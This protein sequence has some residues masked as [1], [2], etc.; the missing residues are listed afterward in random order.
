MQCRKPKPH[1]KAAR[2]QTDDSIID[3]TDEPH[4][5]EVTMSDPATL[6]VQ[7]KPMSCQT[8][9]TAKVAIQQAPNQRLK[10][11][12]VDSLD[13]PETYQTVQIPSYTGQACIPACT[14]LDWQGICETCTLSSTTQC[15]EA[16]TISASI[17][18][19]VA[20][21]TSISTFSTGTNA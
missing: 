21:S 9:E 12:V 13:T 10:A 15:K 2:Q 17:S 4:A 1:S 18:H 7:S 16:F 8:A 19:R 20:T 6:L 11:R 14:C 5:Q 3:L